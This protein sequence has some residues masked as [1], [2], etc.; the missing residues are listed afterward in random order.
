MASS[1][2]VRKAGVAGKTA[3]T[4]PGFWAVRAAMA[5]HPCTPKALKARKS[6]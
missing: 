2:A 4:P 1:C 3:R 5:T 6:A